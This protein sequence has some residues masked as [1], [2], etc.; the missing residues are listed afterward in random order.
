M[1]KKC[2]CTRFFVDCDEAADIFERA[3]QAYLADR[4][5]WG[6]ILAI[7]YLWHKRRAGEVVTSE[8]A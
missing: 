1:D 6:R 7:C 5:E 3:L 8:I 4:E 2:G